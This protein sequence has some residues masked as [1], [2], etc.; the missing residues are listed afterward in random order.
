[1]RRWAGIVAAG[2]LALPATAAAAGRDIGYKEPEAP[3]YCSAHFCVHFVSQGPDAPDLTDAG[4]VPGVP[5]YVETVAA[6]GEDA[7]AH[8]NGKL[9]WRL[10]RRDGARGGGRNQTDI[11]LVDFSDGSGRP[12]IAGGTSLDRGGRSSY[13]EMHNRMDSD[14]DNGAGLWP[15]VAHEYGHVLEHAYA[16]GMD[17]WLS[18]GTAEWLADLSRP[19]SGLESIAQWAR[20]P[21]VSMTSSFRTYSDLV[22]DHWIASRYGTAAVRRV[23]AVARSSRPRGFAPAAFDKALHN[24]PGLGFRAFGLPFWREFALLAATSAEWRTAGLPVARVWP[25]VDRQGTLNR[26]GSIHRRLNHLAYELWDVPAAGLSGPLT[27][28]AR[29]AK[30]T[31]SA[32]ALVARRAGRVVRRMVVLP[33]GGS[34][35]VRLPD[36]SRS[37]RITVVLTNA[38]PSARVRPGSPERYLR[39]HRSFTARLS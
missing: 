1:M 37:E 20:F 33:H 7:R 27:L 39:D 32:V 28:R 30:G 18:E 24:L 34:A 14:P 19:Y 25:D 13:I 31:R 26:D 29:V 8:H 36:S 11:Y 35:T 22:F 23:W 16:T 4:G 5:D 21:W 10:P 2:L 3:P 15:V 12:V 9:H 17:T 6:A 38:D